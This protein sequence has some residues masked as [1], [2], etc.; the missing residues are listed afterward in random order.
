MEPKTLTERLT[1]LRYR[2][3]ETSGTVDSTPGG[4]LTCNKNPSIFR[5]HPEEADENPGEYPGLW[6][7]VFRKFAVCLLQNR[8]EGT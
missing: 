2:G 5:A 7:D 8:V 1:F 6:P 4:C 3:A